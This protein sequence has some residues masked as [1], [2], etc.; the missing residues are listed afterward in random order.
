MTLSIVE[1]S[2]L[3]GDVTGGAKQGFEYNSLTQIDLG[4]FINDPKI[5]ILPRDSFHPSVKKSYGVCVP[6]FVD[7]YPV[8]S[9]RYGMAYDPN[10]CLGDA[11]FAPVTYRTWIAPHSNTIYIVNVGHPPVTAP[12]SMP[13]PREVQPN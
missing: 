7:D 5:P 12:G 9:P 13:V 8:L 3:F 6:I 1:N 11:G 10:V 2:E 4:H